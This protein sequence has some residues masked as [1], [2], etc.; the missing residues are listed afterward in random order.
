MGDTSTSMSCD[1]NIPMYNS[2]GF[3]IRVSEDASSV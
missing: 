2:I 3:S 1:D